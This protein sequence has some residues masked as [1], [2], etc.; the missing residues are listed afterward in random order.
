MGM[1]DILRISSS[2][3]KAER[4]RMETISTNLANASTTKT[5]EGGPFKKKE[6]VFMPAEVSERKSF[7]SMLEQKMDGVKVDEI[8]ESR[9]PF[10]RVYDPYHPQA[11]ADGYVSLPNVNVMEEMSDMVAATRAYE[12]NVNVAGSVKQMFQKALEIGQ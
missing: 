11:D 1:L 7:E 5:D 6:V 2:G 10:E 9:K 12:A 8:V 3:M 4:T